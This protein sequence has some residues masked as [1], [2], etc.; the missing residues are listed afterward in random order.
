[1]LISLLIAATVV[2]APMATPDSPETAVQ[3]QVEA[4]NAHDLDSFAKCYSDDIAFLGLDGK[5]EATS[6]IVALRKDYA[7]LFKRYP[8]V[9]VQ[10]LKRIVQ[11]RFVIDQERTEGARPSPMTATAIYE[12]IQGKIVRVRFL[13]DQ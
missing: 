12:V 1:M 6:G 9:K 5:A 10:I 13:A 3:R 11:G 8:K 7:E 2:L 4:Y